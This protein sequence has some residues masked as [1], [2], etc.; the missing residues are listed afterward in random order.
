MNQDAEVRDDEK[1][2]LYVATVRPAMAPT[3]YV[4]AE[5]RNEPSAAEKEC[6]ERN[7]GAECDAHS[8]SGDEAETGEGGDGVETG[9]G[10]GPTDPT[11]SNALR[12]DGRQ[13]VIG[14]GES[15]SLT[16]TAEETD[17]EPSSDERSVACVALSREERKK[18]R[19]QKK[20]HGMKVRL[21]RRR[22]AEQQAK[23]QEQAAVQEQLNERQK[24]ATEALELQEATKRTKTTAESDGEPEQRTT[25]RVSL[26]KRCGD[27]GV[28]QQNQG[29]RGVEYIGAD[30]GLPTAAIEL[31]GVRRHVKLDSGA[32]YTFAG[33]GWM[34]YGDK[35]DRT[36]PVEFVEGIGGFLLDVIGVW[37]FQ[38]RSV[39]GEDIS[40]EACIVKGC[41]DVFLLG[42][43]F[44]R[45][46]GATMDSERNEI[47]Y[48]E[49]GRVVVVP[50]RTYGGEKKA[51][52]AAVRM[53][54]RTQLEGRTVTP[55]EIAVAAA[56]GE[57][58]VFLPTKQTG[59]VMLAATV[60]TV[61]D[62]KAWVPD[63]NA[64]ES[65]VRL[66]SKRELGTWIP[67]D[68]EM[69][70]L[71]M[72]GGLKSSKVKEWL[73]SL[74]ENSEKPLNDE[75]D[76]HIGVEDSESRGLILRLLRVYRQLTESTG[77]CPP[78][79]ALSTEHHIDT[80]DCREVGETFAAVQG[81]VQ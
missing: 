63:I 37:K 32:R 3:R 40:V 13:E 24:V 77:D 53:A 43:D 76:V 33:P 62:G 20:R 47:R 65:G 17:E 19:K 69:Q 12:K 74:N 2:A 75:E 48:S 67:M 58:G 7:G 28:E 81:G 49:E 51:K 57:V 71:N 52:V 78:A 36:A 14:T 26:V 79:T 38:M 16:L 72:S 4:S 73:K 23:T 6:G 5:P 61:R 42:V 29:E 50:F 35:V 15:P 31:S 55:V 8:N 10:A 9:E 60:T 45:S 18:M 34:K 22:E 66:P 39:F 27:A 80:G 68:R 25:A 41:G 56:D 21:A 44:L 64:Q 46:R 11:D 1:A 59:A 70:V 54:R 30:D